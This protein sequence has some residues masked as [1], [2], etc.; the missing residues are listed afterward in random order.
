MRRS[1]VN[2]NIK[3][4]RA[5]AENSN[6]KLPPFASWSAEDWRERGPECN[7]IRDLMLGWDVTDFALNDFQTTG[8]TLFTLRNGSHQLTQYPRTYSEKFIF[9][10]ED[11]AAPLHF[12]RSK[13]EDIINR[14]GGNIILQAYKASS[15][16]QKSDEPFALSI[17][18]CTVPFSPGHTCR[19]TPGESVLI[20]AGIIHAFWS[21]KGTG[22]TVSGEIGNICDDINDNVFLV[23][24][25][26]FCSI[27]EDELPI[28]LLC[29]EY[30]APRTEEMI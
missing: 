9:I 22:M 30:S 1:E 24:C 18:G 19:L 10:E 2:Q 23:P 13:T 21:E 16:G 12:H 15:E 5:F 28:A 3:K 14:A 27:E 6:I 7:E 8:R 26:R 25:Q 20:P 29:H 4:A 17:N 11:Q